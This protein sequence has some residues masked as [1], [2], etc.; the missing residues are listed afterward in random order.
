LFAVI[1][2][3]GALTAA[4][5]V[6]SQVARM[7]TSAA[8]GRP[9]LD[10]ALQVASLLTA[11]VPV[12]LAVHLLGR[13]GGGLR[14]VGLGAPTARSLR[15][16]TIFGASLA[17][18]VGGVGIGFY[19]IAWRTG[20][21]LTVAPSNL[22]DVW[23]RI[24]VLIASAVQNGLVEEVVVVGYL[25]VRL[26]QLGWGEHGALVASAFLRG[27]YHLYQGLGGFAGNMIMGLLFGRIFQRTGRVF[28]L[29]VAHSLIDIVAFVGYVLLMG[30]VSWLPQG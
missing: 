12:L 9:W 11:M 30:N 1:R 5:P 7:N 19:L 22:P 24:P 13:Y 16:D 21:N 26:R 28:P 8:P 20:G 29:V 2:Y 17:A 10:L 18:A 3:V 27:S 6:R 14:A 23:W 4:A 15:R 25:L